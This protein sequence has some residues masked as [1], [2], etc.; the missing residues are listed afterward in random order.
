MKSLD[1][2]QLN[3]RLRNA[4]RPGQ[5]DEAFE[6]SGPPA[7]EMRA[8][9]TSAAATLSD[10]GDDG[11]RMTPEAQ[12]E[13]AA[14]VE[15]ARGDPAAFGA[16]YERYVD[17]IYAYIYHRVNNVQDA[18][19]LTARTFYRALDNLDRY[20]DRGAPFAAWLFRIAHNLVAN[21]YRD[22]GRRRFLSLDHL[23]GHAGE[24]D[25]PERHA[26]QSETHAALW[27]AINRLPEERRKLLQ[28]K[29]GEQMSNLEIGQLLNKSESG[30]KSLYF[31]TLAALRQ[32]LETR[33]WGGQNG[34]V[35]DESSDATAADVV[36]EQ[37]Q[38]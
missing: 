24:G 17:R 38:G 10:P 27:S 34:T 4:L 30:I 12:A 1:L 25:S 14:L 32:D 26:E 11:F 8:S 22:H 21:W 9:D 28:F 37:P 7:E 35:V 33:G 3:R 6:P 15:R 20:E 19:D 5:S 18:E 23:W 2:G 16:L 31:R 36:S 13:E 29:F